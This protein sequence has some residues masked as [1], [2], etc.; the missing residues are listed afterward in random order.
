MKY[1][2]I[3][4]SKR[5]DNRYCARPTINNKQVYIYGKT[6]KECLLKLKQFYNNLT[7]SKLEY[8]NIK[9]YD[10]IDKW[11]NTY[12][13]PNLKETSL[14]SIRICINKHIKPNIENY[15]LKDL[16]PMYINEALNKITSSRMKKYTY[17]CYI[18]ALREAYKNDLLE[19]DI[20]QLINHITHIRE[21]GT[22]LTKEQRIIFLEQ[23]KNIR[24]GNIFEF[25]FYSG[26]RP[27]GARLLKWTDIKENYIQINETK[28][29]N[30]KRN[31]PLFDKIKEILNKTE[32]T[33]EYVFN[34]SETTIKREFSKLK[35]LC[36]FEFTQKTL[37]HTFA[38]MCAENNINDITISKWL[39]HSNPN[40]TKKYYIDV[41]SDFE[42][43]QKDIINNI[44]NNF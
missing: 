28:S 34:I 41:L 1:K 5:K 36:N 27:Q 29:I 22:A 11:Y 7:H 17:D 4:I 30:G 33:S 40:T 13:K 37:R 24:Y 23:T 38:T 8:K 6:N 2:N 25:M 19:K 32:K 43:K 3:T 31:L 14:N 42:I 10:W 21:K 16:K 18:D 39:G 15:L 9:L 35:E 20:T 26:C 44:F 12:K